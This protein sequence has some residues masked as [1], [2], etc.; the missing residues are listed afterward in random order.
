MRSSASSWLAVPSS[1]MLL[2]ISGSGTSGMIA[3][4]FSP[5]STI[6]S[7]FDFADHPAAVDDDLARSARGPAG[8]T[9]SSAAYLPATFSANSS[10]TATF[11][12][13]T[14]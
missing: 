5:L 8:K 12:F 1:A 3:I 11:T 2:R 6:S 9:R 7:A 4:C 13:A 14:S 10:P